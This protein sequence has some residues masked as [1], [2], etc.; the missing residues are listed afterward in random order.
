[1]ADR[2]VFDWSVG[3]D[4]ILI[5]GLKKPVAGPIETGDWL[6]HSSQVTTSVTPLTRDWQ[7]SAR[8]VRIKNAMITDLS[9]SGVVVYRRNS[10]ATT[11]ITIIVTA[12]ASIA[13][14]GDQEITL[15]PG[16]GLIHFPGDEILVYAAEGT[17]FTVIGTP[18][19]NVAG[20][21]PDPI[22][23]PLFFTGH[24]TLSES[25]ASF[26][27]TVL[28][29]KVSGPL[30]TYIFDQLIN[31]MILGTVLA[32]TGLTPE[33]PNHAAGLQR[34]AQAL[35][36]AKA[37]DPRF[38]VRELAASLNVSIRKLQGIFGDGPG[39]A[40][41]IKQRRLQEAQHLLTDQRY[42]GLTVN[43]VAHLAGFGS[44]NTLRRAFHEAGNYTPLKYR[45]KPA[46]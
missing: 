39:I 7:S 31:E 38:D 37:T 1:M 27:Q 9:A 5:N 42:G 24:G 18:L 17:R 16:D 43:E 46:N 25:I 30:N 11:I 45:Q 29:S 32:S 4:L 23:T 3:R 36:A 19:T 12:G 21:N 34:E 40:A 35:I 6:R 22:R 8:S 2:G 28:R 10:V 15:A 26:A 20:H 14:S 33:R 13:H 41:T 44:A